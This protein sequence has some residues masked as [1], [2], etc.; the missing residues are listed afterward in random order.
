MQNALTSPQCS[1][2]APA[3]PTAE[4]ASHCLT[5]LQSQL[6][7]VEALT[8]ELKR[9]LVHHEDTLEEE[10][11]R[12]QISTLE[13]WAESYRRGLAAA[14]KIS[15]KAPVWLSELKEKLKLAADEL[16]RLEA[17]GGNPPSRE[18]I[19]KADDLLSAMSHIDKV[20]PAVEHIFPEGDAAGEDK[21]KPPAGV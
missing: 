3:P 17:E 9:V 8:N 2:S 4:D 13:R 12:E 14:G 20:I 21:A 15:E 5:A 1:A 18:Q 16:N 7:Q 19:A 10:G 6:A 11:I